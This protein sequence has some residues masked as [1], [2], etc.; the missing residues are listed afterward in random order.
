M[1]RIRLRLV[2]GVDQKIPNSDIVRKKIFRNLNLQR[3]IWKNLPNYDTIDKKLYVDR[4]YYHRA[5]K[6]ELPTKIIVVVDQSGSMLEA[7]VQT[8]ILASIFAELPKV[9]VDLLAF[10]T[11]Y[12]FNQVCKRPLRSVIKH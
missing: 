10:D 4:L 5:G 8:V 12:R 3:T 7:M 11:S 1:N 6:K 2:R 9:E